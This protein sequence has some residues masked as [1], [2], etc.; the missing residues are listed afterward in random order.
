M[1]TSWCKVKKIVG[2]N[3]LDKW[4]SRGEGRHYCSRIR[5]ETADLV[6]TLPMVKAKNRD[7]GGIGTIKKWEGTYVDGMYG[8]NVEEW[9]E[10][11]VD[12]LVWIIG[13]CFVTGK[14]MTAWNRACVA[15]FC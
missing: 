2:E 6:G 11:I 7:G 5:L 14:A 4:A 3:W 10:R 1:K 12:W 13:I 15:S 9:S 8:R